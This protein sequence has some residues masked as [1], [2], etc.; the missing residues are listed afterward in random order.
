MSFGS[1]YWLFSQSQHKG[2]KHWLREGLSIIYL[3]PME[4]DSHRFKSQLDQRPLYVE[5]TRS[6]SD[7]FGS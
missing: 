5:S 2:G 3:T 1:A 6:F 4:Q 7:I